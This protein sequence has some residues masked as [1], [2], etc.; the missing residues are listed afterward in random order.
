[1]RGYTMHRTAMLT[2]DDAGNMRAVLGGS[3]LVGVPSNQCGQPSQMSTVE[4]G[5]G[6][7]NGSVKYGNTHARIAK[8]LIPKRC[9]D[10][11]VI[12]RGMRA[13]RTCSNRHLLAQ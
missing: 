6:L 5:V 2:K 7:V 4:A 13:E 9:G 8:R 11:T 1:M 12:G 3:P 10:C